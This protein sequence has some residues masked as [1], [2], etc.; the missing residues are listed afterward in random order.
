MKKC[1]GKK[2]RFLKQ[3]STWLDL[4]IDWSEIFES[5]NVTSESY[6]MDIDGP[7]SF[8]NLSD[9]QKRR[10]TENLK[11]SPPEHINYIARKNLR[12]PDAKFIYDFIQKYPENTT[13]I[14]KF[15]EDLLNEKKTEISK[16]EALSVY[17]N[18]DLTKQQYI[19]I[20]S[21]TN[22]LAPNLFPCYDYVRAAKEPCYP[23]RDSITVS[24]IHVKIDLQALLDTTMSRLMQLATVNDNDRDLYYLTLVVKWG[25]DGAS[26]Q[27]NYK[28]KFSNSSHN[29]SSIF[30]CS[31]V[32]VKMYD[33]STG[34]IQW[35]NPV[36]S[37][38][39]FC[40][41]ISFR[42]EK[43]NKA[44]T[45]S[46]IEG[47]NQEINNLRPFVW[48]NVVVKY[49]LMFTMVD[50]KICNDVTSTKSA[51]TCFICGSTP[52]TMN[53]V[54]L[55]FQ[56]QPN[57][58]SYKFGI[59]PLH[60]WIRCFECMLHIAYRISFK[61][62]AVQKNTKHMKEQ[63]KL[64]IQN[65]FKDKLSLQVDFV[66][67]GAGTSNDGNTARKFFANY[68]ISAEI[69]G[70]DVG[71]LKRF[72]IILQVL[73]SGLK[74]NI[75]AYRKYTR[76]TAELYVQLYE[77]YYMPVTVHKI[78]VH[79]ADIIAHNC[80]LPIGHLSEDAQ[81]ASHKVFRYVRLHH[82]RKCSR[83]ASNTDLIKTMLLLSD[84]VVSSN[85]NRK[86]HKTLTIDAKNLIEESE[87]VNVTYTN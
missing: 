60:A 59:S 56:R 53:N 12:N 39:R 4:E 63:R 69:T 74:I 79:G 65:E 26:G 22:K 24:D 15:C 54:Q 38:S 48:K 40:R 49:K 29:D 55:A 7:D 67:Q 45:S 72:Y 35:Q 41:P 13:E 21:C 47:I 10:R 70:I 2:N 11:N 62:W 27:S 77:W 1:H 87:N 17:V 23:N 75:E 66:K 80:I 3:Y 32:P 34:A 5:S 14:R 37:S 73:S 20:R 33:E 18:T 19:D 82:T 16:E 44:L 78:L 85:V 25:C 81:E 46:T 52:K 8:S 64:E 68:I 86:N 6:A 28:Q 61:C 42:F 36:P 9:R 58:D 71:L 57:T 31:L 76:E 51:M 30:L 43:E 83:V 84:P 50:T